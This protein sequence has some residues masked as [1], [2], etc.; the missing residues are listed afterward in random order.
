[1]ITCESCQTENAEAAQFCDE[2]GKPLPRASAPDAK[3]E[4]ARPDF[5]SQPPAEARAAAPNG[6]GGNGSRPAPLAFPEASQAR[7]AAA[8]AVASP[9]PPAEFSAQSRP[10]LAAHAVLTINRG[11]S[12]GKDFPVHE[13]EAYIGRWDADSGIFPDVDLD[14]DDPEA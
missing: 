8:G 9:A 5:R 2:C 3:T 14:A 6:E 11:R 4:P 10:P 13:D 1:M 7:A 12:A